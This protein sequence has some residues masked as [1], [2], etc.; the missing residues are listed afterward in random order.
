MALWAT[1]ILGPQA[2]NFKIPKDLQK[3]IH[4]YKKVSDLGNLRACFNLALLYRE[5]KDYKNALLYL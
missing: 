2:P 1:C 4:Y 5:T 3:A